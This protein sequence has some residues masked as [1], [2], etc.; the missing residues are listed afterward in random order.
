MIA[1]T[2]SA[3]L[4][5]DTSQNL[6]AAQY[7]T[8]RGLG[9]AWAS[10]YVPHAG[11]SSTAPGIL[12]P[13]ELAACLA[14][15]FG[16][17]LISYPRTSQTPGGWTT[18]TGQ[19]D[20]QTAAA[21][22]RSLGYPATACLWADLNPPPS[23]Q[24]AIDYLNGFYQGAVAGGMAGS[25]V[26][27]YMEPGV[28]LTASQRYSALKLARYWATAANDS[29]RYPTPR[30]CQLVQLWEGQ[31]GFNPAPGIVIDADASQMDWLGAS[32]IAA[33]AS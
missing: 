7:A 4:G 9:Y 25:A 29:N 24:A 23:S 20:G 31:K 11:Q 1:R 27:A 12:Q 28:P 3:A 30:G 26:G 14:A 8:L 2:L 19:A 32:P 5:F 6:T 21:Y 17:M 33:Y 18:S 16:L 13:G 22:A 15:G 10:R